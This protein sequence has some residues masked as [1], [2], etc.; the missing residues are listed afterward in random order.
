MGGTAFVARV[1]GLSTESRFLQAI[2]DDPGP[3]LSAE[4]SARLLTTL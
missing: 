2:A 4:E 1:A 3:E